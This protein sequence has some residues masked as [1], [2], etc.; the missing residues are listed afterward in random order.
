M[1]EPVRANIAIDDGFDLDVDIA[2]AF[3]RHALHAK[4][5]LGGAHETLEGNG[6]RRPGSRFPYQASAPER[7]LHLKLAPACF[8]TRLLEIEP[9]TLGDGRE[10]EKPRKVYEFVIEKRVLPVNPRHIGPPFR[11]RLGDGFVA[12]AGMRV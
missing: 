11:L 12:L 10:S 1:I 7:I 5:R 4:R 3:E 2:I 8:N 9:L 6:D